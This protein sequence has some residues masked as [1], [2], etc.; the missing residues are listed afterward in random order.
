MAQ[1]YL[2]HGTY[3]IDFDIEIEA[4]SPDDARDIVVSGLPI[5]TIV[6]KSFRLNP[7]CDVDLLDIIPSD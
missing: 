6:R 3:S 1:K 2:V 5:E 4:D 7:H